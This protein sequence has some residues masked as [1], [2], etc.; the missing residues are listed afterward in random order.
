MSL[1]EFQNSQE[2]QD[3]QKQLQNPQ[4]HQKTVA[5]SQTVNDDDDFEDALESLDEMKIVSPTEST[6]SSDE[7]MQRAL[8]QS[9]AQHA[10]DARI[11]QQEEEDMI[12]AIQNSLQDQ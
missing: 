6:G 2:L 10:E 7:Q 9:K 4:K 5:A 1:K 12:K 8:E 11:S 3:I